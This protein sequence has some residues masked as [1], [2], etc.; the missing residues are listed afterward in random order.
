[1]TEALL[2]SGAPIGA[3]N[4]TRKHLSQVKGGQLARLA[5]PATTIA[6]IVS[7]VVGSPLDVIASGPTV[8]DPTTAADARAAL[9]RFGVWEQAPESI[10][11]HLEAVIAG[12]A[13]ETPKPGDP[14]FERVQNVI[15]A[16]NAL[17]AEAARERAEAL[18]FHATIATTFLE[19][20]AREVAVA[21]ASIG[22]EIAARRP[23]PRPACG[24]RR[25]TT[26][27]VRGAGRAVVIRN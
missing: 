27:T 25:E 10:R 8:A 14:A 26:V 17:A 24:V 2:R 5:Y 9:E 3:L 20:E 6:L 19:G 23:V 7:D 16:D 12:D 4:T 22:K 11:R 21:L 13:P 18:G 15:V 1:M